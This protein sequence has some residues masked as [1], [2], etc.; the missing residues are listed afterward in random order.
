MSLSDQGQHGLFPYYFGVVLVWLNCTFNDYDWGSICG[1]FGFCHHH[2]ASSIRS[3][4][5]LI[6][7]IDQ[8]KLATK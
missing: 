3:V 8:S 7:A 6:Y 2:K 1:L 4:D 5:Y